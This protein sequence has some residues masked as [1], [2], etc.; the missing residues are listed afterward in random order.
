MKTIEEILDKCNI[1]QLNEM[2][3]ATS[4]AI[5]NT[6]K[7]LMLLSPTGSGKTLAYL[8]PLTQRI[9]PELDAVQA[10]VV[11]PGRELALQSA[12]VLKDMATGLRAYA[13]Y[14][15][16]A[17]MDEHRQLRQVRPHVI[18]STPGRMNDH[19]GKGNI[20]TKAVKWIIL[21]EFDKCLEMGFHDEMAI[22]MRQIP[23]CA[24]QILLSATP[25]E[26]M[27]T[28]QILRDQFAVLNFL[29]NEGNVPARVCIRKVQSPEKDKLETLRRLLCQLGDDSSIVF[30]NYRESVERTAAYLEEHGFTI[31][32]FHGGL[33]QKQREDALYR[34][35]NGSANI[36][37]STD[38]ASRGLDIPDI[39]NIIHYHLP[40]GEDGYIHR[41]GRTARW[42]AHGDSY[43]ILGPEESIPDY[44][45]A[46]VEDYE[47]STEAAPVPVPRMATIYIGKGKKD[48]ISKGDIVGLLCKQAGLSSSEIGRIDVKDY[49]AY[50]AV[51]RSKL[52]QVL[53]QL[54][55]QKIKGLKTLFEAV[56]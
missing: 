34:F 7:D 48:K 35:S 15:G 56:R 4:E 8:L 33:E 17:A 43:F 47:L 22:L 36:L 2:Q 45:D 3:I 13:C 27:H 25:A 23:A 49:Y 44:V 11:V 30:L 51:V 37:V 10:I 31:S 1:R 39:R 5:L 38:L 29:P 12:T 19:L 54:N 9:N 42:D 32:S 41:V 24:R 20:D 46:D 40:E 18:F 6:G 14:G 52:M 21:D 55:G 50:V 26:E 53:K 16:R 28:Q